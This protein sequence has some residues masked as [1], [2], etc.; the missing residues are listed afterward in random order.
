MS[1]KITPITM[2]PT[3]AQEYLNLVKSQPADTIYS[4]ELIQLFLH[5]IKEES[6]TE[7]RKIIAKTLGF[8]TMHPE[9]YPALVEV[10][11]TGET[12]LVLKFQ[13]SLNY[14]AG[15]SLI[16]FTENLDETKALFLRTLRDAPE[17]FKRILAIYLLGSHFPGDVMELKL[18]FKKIFREDK[19][20]K[21][22]AE[23]W[24]RFVGIVLEEEIKTEQEAL[25]REITLSAIY[26][27]LTNVQ[28]G[29]QVPLTRIIELSDEPYFAHAEEMRSY[30]IDLHKYSSEVYIE[31]IQEI[32]TNKNIQGKYFEYE[33]VFV[34][35]GKESTP[36]LAPVAMSKNYLCHN[37]GTPIEKDTKTCSACKKEIPKCNVCKLPISFGEDAGKCSLC[38]SKGHLVHFQEWVKVK[39]KCPTCLEKIPI[40]GIVPLTGELKK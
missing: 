38:E 12:G 39:G 22:R 28:P 5:T 37:C 9:V 11:Q 1:E 18:I 31:L 8:L 29:I 3:I 2:N 4:E 10:F 35:E 25:K 30:G 20:Q 26:E 6:N 33:Q 34:R 7:I 27:V 24:L 32:I 36:A 14:F 21:V 16:N 19:S 15:L 23:A 13:N 17:E 40:E